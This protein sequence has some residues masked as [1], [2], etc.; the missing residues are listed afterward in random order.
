MKIQL[1]FDLH[2][3]VLERNFPGERLIAPLQTPTS[4]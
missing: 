1:A 4:W 2:L 3:E